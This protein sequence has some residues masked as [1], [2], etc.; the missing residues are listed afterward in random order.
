MF[1]G[2]TELSFLNI[3]WIMY[4]T[5]STTNSYFFYRKSHPRETVTVSVQKS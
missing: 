3:Y 1:M 4:I 5:N 2:L